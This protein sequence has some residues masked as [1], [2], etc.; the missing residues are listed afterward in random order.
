[1]VWTHALEHWLI[2]KLIRMVVKLFTT[3][4]T[5]ALLTLMMI[6]QIQKQAS[7][8]IPMVVLY[9]KIVM[10]MAFLTQTISV[11]IHLLEFQSMKMDVKLSS[12]P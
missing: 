6:V 1:M 5:M 9:R 4:T 8:S 7:K 2:S 12:D 11:R 3:Q 10:V